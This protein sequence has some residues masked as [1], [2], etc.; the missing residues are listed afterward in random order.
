MGDIRTD[1]AQRL[2]EKTTTTKKKRKV[3]LSKLSI[4]CLRKYVVSYLLKKKFYTFIRF[5]HGFFKNK[6]V[7]RL[8][9]LVCGHR[10]ILFKWEH[11]GLTTHIYFMLEQ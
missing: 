10:M 5:D 3:K 11:C 4:A 7:L 9:L 2:M 8:V 6:F 1:C